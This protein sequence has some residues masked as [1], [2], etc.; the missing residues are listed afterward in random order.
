MW[1]LLFYI[2]F[3]I[4]YEWSEL[5]EYETY[6]SFIVKIKCANYYGVDWNIKEWQLLW[7]GESTMKNVSE[8]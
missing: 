7:N 4:K 8:R 1:D 3:I 2:N 5:V 6:L